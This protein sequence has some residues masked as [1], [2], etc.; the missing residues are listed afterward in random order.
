MDIS[1]ENGKGPAQILNRNNL[2]VAAVHV[3]RQM[4]TL[5]PLNFAADCIVEHF[6][7][8]DDNIFPPATHANSGT[9]HNSHDG[10]AKAFMSLGCMDQ[11]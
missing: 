10:V 3:K 4:P 2:V 11:H 8:N 7:Q 5:P 9:L 1:E 6:Q